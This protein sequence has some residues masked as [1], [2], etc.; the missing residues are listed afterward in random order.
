MTPKQNKPSMQIECLQRA[1]RKL[2]ISFSTYG[3]TGNFI[4]LKMKKPLFFVN[5]STPFNSD[6]TVK[7]C[8]DK[9]FT[10]NLVSD[11]VQMP[12]T[13]GFLDPGCEKRYKNYRKYYNQ[14]E[15]AQ[16][17]SRSFSWPVVLKP[18]AKE[19]G[20]N[21]FFCT[22]KECIESAL[23]TIFNQDSKNYDYVAIAQEYI[24]IKREF[25]A[26][27]FEKRIVL[28][29]EKH[30]PSLSKK[31]PSDFYKK[32]LYTKHIK[33]Q[34]MTAKIENF[35]SPA[36]KALNAS[37][38]GADIAMGDDKLLYLLEFNSHPGFSRFVK[39]NGKEDLVLMYEKILASLQVKQGKKLTRT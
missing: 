37:F 1:C 17:I 9:E 22:K 23:K 15:I 10:Y 18:N 31:S 2:N 13:Q 39:D 24:N 38:V 19:R 34:K 8:R 20:K 4:C 33:N 21:I 25:R 11:L 36:F 29:Y 27:F 14:A 30:I 12:Q 7:I 26:V 3:N 35:V 5:S 6:S 16:A 32:G 28:L